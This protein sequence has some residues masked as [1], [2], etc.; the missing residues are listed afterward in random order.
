M[1]TRM[2]L[3]ALL[4]CLLVAGLG[5]LITPWVD[6]QPVLLSPAVRDVLRYA[7]RGE[8]WMEDLEK[9]EQLLLDALPISGGNVALPAPEAVRVAPGALLNYTERAKRA[10]GLAMAVAKETNTTRPPEG[11]EGLHEKALGL[12]QSY[13]YVATSVN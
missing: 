13:T 5:W 2:V 11:L 12:C 1:K 4:A 6:G 3:I 9:V 8:D 10:K 7:D